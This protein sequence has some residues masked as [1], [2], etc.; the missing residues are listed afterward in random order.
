MGRNLNTLPKGWTFGREGSLLILICLASLA[1]LTSVAV[2]AGAATVTDRPLLFSFDG[3][4]TT[5]G[6]FERPLAIATGPNGEVYVGDGEVVD[7]FNAEGEAQ[8]FVASGE[9]SLGGFSGLITSLAVDNSG[10]NTGR[11]YVGEFRGGVQA[12]DPEGNHLWTLPT[13]EVGGTVQACGISVDGNGHLWTVNSAKGGKETVREFAS[14]GSPPAEVTSFNA[15]SGGC[16]SHA[17]GVGVDAS[18][19]V[20]VKSD[21]DP[22]ISHFDGSTPS[23]LDKY[24]G[25]VPVSGFLEQFFESFTIDQSQAEGHTLALLGSFG[26]RA[27]AFREGSVEELESSGNKVGGFAG[28]G[29]IGRGIGIAYNPTKDRLY[30]TDE[31][32]KTVKAFGPQVTGTAPDVIEKPTDEITRTTATAHATIDPLAVPNEYRFEWAKGGNEVQHL[33]MAVVGDFHAAIEGAFR[34]GAGGKYTEQLP[35]DVK[36]EILQSELEALPAIGAGNVAVSGTTL[37]QPSGRSGDYD[38]EFKGEL[39]GIDVPRLVFDKAGL[40]PAGTTPFIE[41]QLTTKSEGPDWASACPANC[42]SSENIEP[43]DNASHSLSL[44]IGGLNNNT[45]YAVRLVATNSENHLQTFATDVFKTLPPPQ[46]KIAGLAVSAITTSAAH[47]GA[48]IDPTEEPEAGTDWRILLAAKVEASKAQCEALAESKF[49][50]VEEG[51]LAA[52]SPATPIAANLSS[53]LPAQSYCIRVVADNGAVAVDNTVFET[54][55]VVPTQVLTAFAAPR[56]DTTARINAYVNP[57]GAPLAYR[58]EFSKDG[59]S[60]WTP[61]PAAEDHSRARIPVVVG[62]ELPNLQ[63]NTAYSYRFFAENSAGE[64]SPQGAVKEFK[65]RTT[66]EMSPPTRG[67]ELVNNPDKGEQNVVPAVFGTFQAP[68]SPNGEKAIWG[69]N[70]GAPGSSSPYK[71]AFL[72]TRSESGWHSSSVIP[73]AA[74]QVGGGSFEYALL[75]ASSDYSRYLFVA[76]EPRATHVGP[77]TIVRGAESGGQEVLEEFASEKAAA[78]LVQSSD[79]LSHVL[80]V[81]PVSHQ[82]EDVGAGSRTPLSV[83]PDGAPNAC[84]LNEFGLSFGGPLVKNVQVGGAGYLWHPGYSQIATTDASRFYFEAIPNGNPCQTSKQAL[85]ERN[86]GAK[87]GKGETTLIDSGEFGMEPGADPGHARWPKRLL[88]HRQQ[89]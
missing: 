38:F 37:D 63:P 45:E 7:K 64:A 40:H 46:P 78:E 80:L 79:D 85:Y 83:M 25:G 18:G 24:V 9:S 1:L 31:D 67:V 61:L 59:G 39:K 34:L 89:A 47:V 43:P 49:T 5:Q 52:G 30:V 72:A 21:A 48:S 65:T 15:P 68:V 42:S 55:P 23:V 8:S 50:K 2:P 17:N 66:A 26:P 14:S 29:L 11:L 57:E 16:I 60:T 44:P 84:G 10:V 71:G 32:S 86:R 35:V 6:A 75:S 20:F 70:A 77:P 73:P 87:K 33:H 62:A 13:G 56:T 4:D 74:Q 54:K 88:P 82:I 58:F 76:A 27:G 36:P 53:L 22:V 41:T 69:V 28:H 51:T 81:D 19:S 3:A 12:F